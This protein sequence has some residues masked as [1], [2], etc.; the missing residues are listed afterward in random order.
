MAESVFRG[1]ISFFGEIGLFDVVL[2][3]LLVF[4]IVFAIFEKT[5]VFGTEDIDGKKY[6]K[7]NLNAMASFV[8]SFLVIA[9]SRLVEIVTTVSSQVIILLMLSVL[10][11]LLIGSFMREGDPIFLEGGWKVFFMFI[12]FIGIVIIFLN[13]IKTPAGDTW[14][15][16]F[17]DVV[18]GGK[19]S[20]AIGSVILIL[21]IVFFMM[22]VMKEPGKGEKKESE[23]K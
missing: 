5:K 10:F 6:T 18:S 23:K 3:F 8:I 9:S 17:W 4:T 15:Q 12:M 21:I 13:A 11:L 16:T 22:F 1:I 7:K 14:L 20:N 19:T 2:P